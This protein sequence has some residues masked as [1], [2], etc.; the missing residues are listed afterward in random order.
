M[1]LVHGLVCIISINFEN[2]LFLSRLLDFTSAT[3]YEQVDLDSCLLSKQPKLALHGEDGELPPEPQPL[4]SPVRRAFFNSMVQ[5]QSEKK[6]T[7]QRTLKW[8]PHDKSTGAHRGKSRGRPGSESEQSVS[9]WALEH[10]EDRPCQGGRKE[11]ETC[12]F[13]HSPSS[14][15]ALPSIG[16]M[17]QLEATFQ[18][19]LGVTGSPL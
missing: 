19:N 15:P 16:W 12:S 5:V 7:T 2:T 10:R 3:G 8:G 13:S 1:T 11:G 14:L 6:S 17:N 9:Q 4:P 18:R